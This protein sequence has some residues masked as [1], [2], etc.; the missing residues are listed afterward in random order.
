MISFQ[1]AYKKFGKDVSFESAS[2]Q[3]INILRE[4]AQ[5]YKEACYSKKNQERRM[6]WRRFNSLEKTH[7]PFLMQYDH[8]VL[9]IS[10]VLSKCRT[11]TLKFAEFFFLLMLWHFENIDDDL[12]LDPWISVNAHRHTVP[13]TW[14]IELDT[15]KDSKTGSWTAKPV[16]TCEK[17]LKRLVPTPHIVIDPEPPLAQA[18]KAYIGDILPVHI[19]RGSVYRWWN[20]IDLSE[21]L[22][23]LVG[24]QQFLTMM[25]DD[26]QLLHSLL[27]ILQ[28]GILENLKEVARQGDFAVCDMY[29]HAMLHTAGL[30]EPEP[31]RYTSQT[32]DLW[33]FMHAQEF[34]I[35]GPDLYEEFMFNY[36]LPIMKNFGLISYGCCEALDNKMHILRRLP[37]LRRVCVGPV[38]DLEKSIEKIGTDYILSWRPGIS[39]VS[40]SYNL[41]EIFNNIRNG[42]EK[43]RGTHTE[44]IIKDIMTL[45]NHPERLSDVS[46]IC[47]EAIS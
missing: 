47:R 26:P 29:N 43:A 37:N 42:I 38:A 25:Y 45:D 41:E 44:L 36:Q 35:V 33:L 34:D 40:T 17:D 1:S 8:V 12:V 21:T 6:L 31:C 3:E 46:K 5:R 23:R 4:L 32:E 10:P 7:T 27:S 19:K 13:G 16:I 39:L 18:M 9:E 22:L 15:H 2:I 20:G 30:P 24:Y 11:K 14:G 28:K